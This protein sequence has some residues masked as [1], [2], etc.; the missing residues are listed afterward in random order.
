MDSSLTVSYYRCK[1][2]FSDAENLG[3]GDLFPEVVSAAAVFFCNLAELITNRGK[4]R[5]VQ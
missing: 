1:R 3:N 2:I 4:Y 5:T